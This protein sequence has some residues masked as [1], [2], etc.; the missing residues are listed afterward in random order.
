MPMNSELPD[1]QLQLLAYVDGEL[2]QPERQEVED[3]LRH[4]PEAQDLLRELELL[5]RHQREFWANVEPRQP[6]SGQ[7]L[8]VRNALLV[9]LAQHPKTSPYFRSK[10]AWAILAGIAVAACAMLAI[11]WP[12]TNGNVK[13][14]REDWVQQPIPPEDPLAE[15]AVLPIA[16]SSDVM[17]IAIHGDRSPGLVA[18]D[19]PIP[20]SLALA[21]ADD[22]EI[23]PPNLFTMNDPWE[24]SRPEPSDAPVLMSPREPR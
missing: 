20:T 18:C 15:F 7:W 4:D 10:Y 17:I 23:A 12:N 16:G 6:S 8:A 5:A 13:P 24:V 3:R 1:W 19:H 9:D 11:L 21:T 22:L 14:Q 2:P